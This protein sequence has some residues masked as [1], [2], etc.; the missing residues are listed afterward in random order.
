M[1]SQKRSSSINLHRMRKFFALKPVAVGVASIFLTACG[2]RQEGVIYTTLDECI[3]DNPASAADV[4]KAAYEEALAEAERTGPKFANQNDCEYE[5]GANQCHHVDT[6][7]GSFFMPFMAGYM[8][9]ELLSPKKRYYTQP[10]Y[11]SYSRYSPFRM[12]WAM[13][14]GYVFDGDIR[15]KRYRVKES[16]FTK[17]PAVSRTISRGG[18]GSTVRAKSS[19]GSSSRKGSWGG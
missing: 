7:Q 8:V 11:T 9:S 5:F 13:A 18:F 10:M 6:N 17:K 14:D 2:D 16:T 1:T 3:N 4:C 19:W 15:D 12:R